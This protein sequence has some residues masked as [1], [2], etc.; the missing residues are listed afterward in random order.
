MQGHQSTRMELPFVTDLLW[1]SILI[2]MNQIMLLASKFRRILV[3]FSNFLVNVSKILVNLP[4][5]TNR[6]FKDTKVFRWIDRL[7]RFTLESILT[8]MNPIPVDSL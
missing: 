2:E 5:R 8:E 1:R 4:V 3:N 6:L 7:Y